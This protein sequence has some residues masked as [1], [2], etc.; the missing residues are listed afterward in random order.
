MVGREGEGSREGRE[1]GGTREGGKGNRGNGRTRADMGWDGKGRERE[2]RKGMKREER[3]YSPQTSIFPGAATGDVCHS[4]C[5]SR[6]VCS[7]TP[8]N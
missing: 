6:P 2:R 8:V 4:A 1:M 7:W 3:G 5:S